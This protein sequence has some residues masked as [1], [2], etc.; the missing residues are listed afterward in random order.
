L[1]DALLKNPI[2][3]LFGCCAFAESGHAAT[4]AMSVKNVRRL[5]WLA[6]SGS[7]FWRLN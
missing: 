5:I 3:G 4:L 1:R 2:S 6:T 7:G